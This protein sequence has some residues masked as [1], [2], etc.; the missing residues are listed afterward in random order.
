M[1]FFLKELDEYKAAIDT[2]LSVALDYLGLLVRP[3][4]Q[5]A[6]DCWVSLQ[7]TVLIEI[8]TI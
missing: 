5:A 8:V 4:E 3:A 1:L 6:D 2:Q 7:G